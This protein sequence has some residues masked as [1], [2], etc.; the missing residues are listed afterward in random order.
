MTRAFTLD[1]LIYWTSW[2]STFRARLESCD[3][4]YVSLAEA[5]LF[6]NASCALSP[7]P[8]F[9]AICSNALLATSFKRAVCSSK[10]TNILSSRSYASRLAMALASALVLSLSAMISLNPF[11]VTSLYSLKFTMLIS[12]P[13]CMSSM[14]SYMVNLSHFS[15]S[16]WI[17]SSS[18][19]V[20]T[21]MC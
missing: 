13:P 1:S 11:E 21:G 19:N 20:S 15:M 17:A 18:E 8:D 10:T 3:S 9:F 5:L 7:A 2:V 16:L 14:S 4:S 12:R 6:S